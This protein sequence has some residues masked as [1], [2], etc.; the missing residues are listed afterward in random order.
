MTDRDWWTEERAARKRGFAVIAGADEAGRGPLAGPVVAAAVILPFEAC[1]AGV[2]DSKT[3][4]P[5]QR[6]RAF[7]ALQ[8][9]ALHIGVGIVGVEEIDRLNILRASQQAMREAVDA[10]PVCP[11]VALIDGLPVQPFPVPQIALVKGDSRSASVAAASIIAKV[12]RDRLMDEYDAL[13]PEYGFAS[14]KGYATPEHLAALAAHGPCSIHRR[15]FAPVAQGT[16]KMDGGGQDAVGDAGPER[17]ANRRLTGDSGEV[18]AAA[19]FRALGWEV[20]ETRY[21]CR[22]GELDIVARDGDTLVFAEVKTRRGRGYGAPAE[23][24]DARKRARVVRAAAAYLAEHASGECACRF[25]V[26]EVV[27]RRDG[28]ATVNLIR[29]AFAAGE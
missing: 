9:C 22:W 10:L 8:A 3:L 4:T 29:N 19:H 26:A 12:T 5:L 17:A 28:L 15:S 27:F 20:L 14:H 25:D 23:A 13:Y 6:E 18:V 1:P 24:V 11:D 7:D 2:R 16:L 21:H